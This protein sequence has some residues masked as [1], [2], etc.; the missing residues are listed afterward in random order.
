[1]VIH[2]STMVDHEL[3][4][5]FMV[6]DQVLLNSITVFDHGSSWSTVVNFV[7]PCP[8]STVHM[9]GFTVFYMRILFCVVKMSDKLS[10]Q[11]LEFQK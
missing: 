7:G 11:F 10:W 1:M 4:C 5:Q 3:P 6:F 8:L 9:V 2:E